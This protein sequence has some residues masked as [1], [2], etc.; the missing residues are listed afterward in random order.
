MCSFE[1]LF[2]EMNF[3]A[4]IQNIGWPKFTLF[5]IM[6]KSERECQNKL[7][8]LAGI[9]NKIPD[10]PLREKRGEQKEGERKARR[11]EIGGER[12]RAVIPASLNT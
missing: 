3:K 1:K 11:E 12:G 8:F 10:T 5:V 2:Y 4:P 7:F 6:K 9:W